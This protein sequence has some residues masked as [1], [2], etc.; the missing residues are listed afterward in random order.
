M[1]LFRRARCKGTTNLSL[2]GRKRFITFEPI[3]DHG[4]QIMVSFWFQ[5]SPGPSTLNKEY[6]MP[7]AVLSNSK[8][9]SQNSSQVNKKL[10]PTKPTFNHS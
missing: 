6:M 1:V 8:E 5:P 2:R 7:T 9:V 10:L 3:K 4:I